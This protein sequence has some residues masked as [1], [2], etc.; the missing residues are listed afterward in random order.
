M[1]RA[2]IALNWNNSTINNSI[3]NFGLILMLMCQKNSGCGKRVC[4]AIEQEIKYIMQYWRFFSPHAAVYH[5]TTVL[6]WTTRRSVHRLLLSIDCQTDLFLV[7]VKWR[8]KAFLFLDTGIQSSDRE[9]DWWIQKL[10]KLITEC[11]DVSHESE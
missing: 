9:A 8:P 6:F 2:I 5:Q 4:T 10:G 3:W 1:V 7:K 11:F